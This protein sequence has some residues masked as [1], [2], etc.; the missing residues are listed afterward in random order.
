M[1]SQQMQLLRGIQ[2]TSFILVPISLEETCKK[3]WQD[4]E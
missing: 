2:A 1:H 3:N 4:G